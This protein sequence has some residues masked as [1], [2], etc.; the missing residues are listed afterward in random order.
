MIANASFKQYPDYISVLRQDFS[1]AVESFPDTELTKLADDLI[2]GALQLDYLKATRLPVHHKFGNIVRNPENAVYFEEAETLKAAW[3]DDPSF[4]LKEGEMWNKG[5]RETATGQIYELGEDGKPINPYM[6][7]GIKGRGILGAFGPNH[8]VDNGMIVIKYDEQG[9]L[10]IYSVLG[11]LRKYDNNAPALAGGFAKYKDGDIAALDHDAIAQNQTDEFFEE[12]IS[13]SIEL[14]PEFQSQIENRL[15]IVLE[16][17]DKITHEFYEEH[18]EQVIT[19]LKME[20][21]EKYDP[22]FLQRL[23]AHI[24]SGHECFAGPVLNDPR[25]TDTAWIESH[26]FWVVFNDQTWR[27][28]KGNDMF[29][30]KFSGGDDASDIIFHKFDPDTVQNAY[31]SH[32]PMMCFMAASYVLDAQA[33]GNKIEESVVAQLQ[34]VADYLQQRHLSL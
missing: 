7:T 6:A 31:A 11:I 30:Y 15:H 13:G 8:A 19:A 1:K 4:P 12:V 26:L 17:Y 20:Q 34:T 16:P 10:S 21:I 32:G 18:E 28:I 14:L 2:Q 23:K 5:H 29:G 33:R 9:K 27:D 25:N 24:R 22:E 3:A